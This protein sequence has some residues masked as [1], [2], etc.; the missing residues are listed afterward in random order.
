MVQLDADS[1]ATK[2]LMIRISKLSEPVVLN[3]SEMMIISVRWR[4]LELINS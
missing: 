1:K 4:I 2:D 3:R